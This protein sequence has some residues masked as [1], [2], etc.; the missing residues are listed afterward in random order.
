KGEP[1][2]CISTPSALILQEQRLN[3]RRKPAAPAS[4]L[5]PDDG[6]EPEEATPYSDFLEEIDS[7]ES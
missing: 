6:L 7:P 3:S 5:L 2:D 4:G 1:L